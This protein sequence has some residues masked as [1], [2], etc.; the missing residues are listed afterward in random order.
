MKKRLAITHNCTGLSTVFIGSGIKTIES[1]A[2]AKC[3]NLSDVYCLAYKYPSTKAN[4]FQN[5]YPDYITLHVPD[6]AVEQYRAVE[7]WSTFKA[8]VDVSS[9]TGAT[10]CAKP[11][12][13]YQ[14]GK[15]T[16]ACETADAQCVTIITVDDAKIYYTS[17]INLSVTYLIS[18]YAIKPGYSNSEIASATLCWIDV[19]PQ[20]EGFTNAVAQMPAHAVL[21][22]SENG[23]VS[24]KGIDDG[25]DG[26]IY[27]TDGVKAGAGVCQG[28]Q[29]VV[30]T[31]MPEG[32][33]A[34]VKIGRR[35]VKVVMK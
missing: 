28:G 15:I 13:G 7:P 10:P 35:S 26:A 6:K 21:I 3:T 30:S 32:S 1:E 20:T 25:T 16:T 23:Q 19:D 8:V 5:S 11:T 24:V 31:N 22:Q 27:G 9:S 4:A 33:I 14:D 12:I 29:A 18:V 34:I 17:D 2:F